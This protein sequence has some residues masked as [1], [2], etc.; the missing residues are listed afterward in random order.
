MASPTKKSNPQRRTKRIQ[1]QDEQFI[2]VR[3]PRS[4]YRKKVRRRDVRLIL[5]KLAK[6]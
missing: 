1:P 2:V 3:S 4:F 6:L 5:D